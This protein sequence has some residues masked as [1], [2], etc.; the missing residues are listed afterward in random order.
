MVPQRADSQQKFKCQQYEQIWSRWWALWSR[1][2]NILV[3]PLWGQTRSTLVFYWDG[4]EV[5]L[6]RLV[7]FF[8][9][10]R[11]VKVIGQFTAGAGLDG[12]QS[13][14]MVVE[15]QVIDTTFLNVKKNMHRP[16]S[17]Y[18]GDFWADVAE[19]LSDVGAQC[20]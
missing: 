18:R 20:K 9:R 17:V 8:R 2:G 4:V 6:N 1:P 13:L 10:Y 19:Q 11:D 15:I 7:G 12:S 5:C 14:S 16:F 3:N